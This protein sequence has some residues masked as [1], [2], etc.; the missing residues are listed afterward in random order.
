MIMTYKGAAPVD[1][2]RVWIKDSKPFDLEGGCGLLG[3]WVVFVPKRGLLPIVQILVVDFNLVRITKFGN[4]LNPMRIIE[5]GWRTR[6]QRQ[7]HGACQ[8]IHTEA[9]CHATPKRERHATPKIERHA[10]QEYSGIY[11]SKHKKF[12]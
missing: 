3:G 2:G 6:W 4:V 10:T 1:C 12:S 8:E 7:R 9:P 5:W 11:K